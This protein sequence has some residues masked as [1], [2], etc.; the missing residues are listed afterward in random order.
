MK[1]RRDKE[2]FAKWTLANLSLV[3]CL[4]WTIFLGQF[5]VFD[6]DFTFDIPEH[7]RWYADIHSVQKDQ[8]T[9]LQSKI[10]AI[11]LFLSIFT[12][13]FIEEHH[14]SN[15][16]SI[17]RRKSKERSGWSQFGPCSPKVLSLCAAC[18]FGGFSEIG[19]PVRVWNDCE[20]KQTTRCLQTFQFKLISPKK[21][22]ESQLFKLDKLDRNL[23]SLLLQKPMVG[24]LIVWPTEV[25]G[26]K[27]CARPKLYS[28]C[29]SPFTLFKR[30]LHQNY[31]SI[32]T[33]ESLHHCVE[34]SI[35]ILSER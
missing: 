9:N 19:L 14:L 15:N 3:W 35:I 23:S 6:L 20:M 10:S 21:I 13:T 28:L 34:G 16:G 4:V 32:G 12:L 31:E 17:F 24:W 5:V 29:N 1:Y 7:V 26:S 22:F 18:L 33:P 25:K 30:I 8:E 27:E 11:T 2:R